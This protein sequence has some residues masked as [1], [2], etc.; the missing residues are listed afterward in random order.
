MQFSSYRFNRMEFAGSIGDLGVMLPLMIALITIN[1]LN[2]TSVIFMAGLFYIIAGIYYKIPVPVQP[3]KVVAAVAIAEGAEIITPGVISA[4]GL[5]MGAFLLFIAATGIV[6]QISKLFPHP[7]V[8]GIQ[9]GLGLILLV[10]AV[11][12]A[13]SPPAGALLDV[14]LNI[15]AGVIGLIIFL[16]MLNN[17]KIPGVIAVVLFGIAASLLCLFFGIGTSAAHISEYS[18][19]GFQMPTLPSLFIPSQSDFAKAFLLL[20]IPQIPLTIG[21]A[22]MS[23]ADLSRHYFKE[24]AKKVTPKALS[25]TM[26]IVNIL[27]GAVGAMPMCHGS[28]GTAAHYF[29]GA[30]TGGSNLMIGGIFIIL[31]LLGSMALMILTLIPYSILGVLLF[32][33]GIELML[34]IRDVSKYDDLF[35]VLVI[36]GL[37]IAAGIATA[38]IIGILLYYSLKKGFVR[39]WKDRRN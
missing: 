18:A 7:I 4:A 35:V 10:K 20:V 26:G 24:N 28:G 19:Q 17:K 29:F 34:M 25:G 9:L 11:E 5:L 33:I 36:G 2:A 3:F 30:R 1:G 21:N 6:K 31:A 23:T 16:M 39:L 8:R 22:V 12:F 37:A 15:A 13:V 27:T 14:N 38:F 32:F